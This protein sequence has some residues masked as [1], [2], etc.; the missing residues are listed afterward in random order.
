MADTRS[1]YE[2]FDKT[3]RCFDKDCGTNGCGCCPGETGCAGC[4]GYP[5]HSAKCSLYPGLWTYP[6]SRLENANL[7]PENESLRRRLMEL[8]VVT[9]RRGYDVPD[10]MKVLQAENNHFRD[11]TYSRLAEVEYWKK[12]YTNERN[13]YNARLEALRREYEDKYDTE[14]KKLRLGSLDDPLSRERDL[15]TALDNQRKEW[16][17]R[18][19]NA[20]KEELERMKRQYEAEINAL[21]RNQPNLSPEELTRLRVENESL[22]RQLADKDRYYAEREEQIRLRLQDAVRD[23]VQRILTKDYQAMQV[24]NDDYMRLEREARAREMN[25]A[26]IEKENLVNVIENFR[27]KEEQLLK[28]RNDL[29]VKVGPI[30]EAIERKLKNTEDDNQKL[31]DAVMGMAKERDEILGKVAKKMDD[32]VK[33]EKAKTYQEVQNA[34]LKE[35]LKMQTST[36]PTTSSTTQQ[37]TFPTSPPAPPSNPTYPQPQNVPPLPPRPNNFLAPPPQQPPRQQTTTTTT[38]FQYGNQSGG[39]PAPLPVDIA[40]LLFPGAPMGGPTPAGPAPMQQGF[41]MSKLAPQFQPAPSNPG[42]AGQGFNAFPSVSNQG[43]GGQG[44]NPAPAPQMSPAA[45]SLEEKLK[46]LQSGINNIMA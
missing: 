8:E 39:L 35:V 36:P 3:C 18:F 7:L 23:E 15:R 22:K 6:F 43:F 34:L 1:F 5:S 9:G 12:L 33:T 42:F 20:L 11:L 4:N 28:E 38:N 37:V 14:L 29:A 10:E 30:K 25:A 31:R 40:K 32:V 21:K 44:F 26:Q 45:Q 19:A 16:E 41:D 27:R 13:N 2:G 17:V 24:I 46:S